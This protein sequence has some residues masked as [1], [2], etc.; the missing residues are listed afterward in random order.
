MLDLKLLLFSGGVESTCLALVHH[1]D[2]LLTVDYGQVCAEGELR[3][4][5]LLAEKLSLRHESISVP[6]GHLGAGD[7]V[8]QA[9]PIES[10][11]SET[12]PFRNQAL[13]TLAAM[14]YEREGLLEIMIGTVKSDGVHPDGTSEFILG[15]GCAIRSQNPSIRVTAPAI[16]M[17]TVELVR[18]SDITRDLLGW[19]FSCHRAAVACGQCRGCTKTVDLFQELNSRD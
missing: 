14:R 3:A 6:M 8:P 5:Q 10:D 15:I 9:P 1:P 11:A 13:I 18:S 2:L 17:S 12:W 7:L 16:A 19:T 4:S